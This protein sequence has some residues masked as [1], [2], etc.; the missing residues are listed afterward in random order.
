MAYTTVILYAAHCV[1]VVVV[2]CCLYIVC[3][4]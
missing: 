3:G 2:R 4:S 1:I